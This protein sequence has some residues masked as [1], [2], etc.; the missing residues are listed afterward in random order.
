MLYP[1]KNNCTELETQI[2]VIKNDIDYFYENFN[3]NQ[4][5]QR[6]S[7]LKQK[8]LQFSVMNCNETLLSN[9]V[10]KLNNIFDRYSYIA[11][12]RIESQTDNQKKVYIAIGVVTILI[13]SYIIIKR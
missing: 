3:E 1:E 6:E 13:A 4:A 5:K 8:E 12:I 10:N 7:I 9:K 2:N 11:K